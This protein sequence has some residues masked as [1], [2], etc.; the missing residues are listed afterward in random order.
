MSNR[1]HIKAMPGPAPMPEAP[2]VSAQP[3]PAIVP[4]TCIWCGQP[5][6]WR[7]TTQH[8]PPKIEEGSEP[9]EEQVRAIAA[10][11]R[12]IFHLACMSEHQWQVAFIQQSGQPVVEVLADKDGNVLDMGELERQRARHAAMAKILV[13]GKIQ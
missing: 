11:D 3:R 5:A 4:L 2:I 1:A 8:T 6:V 9:T 10:G 7:A 12:V 13:P